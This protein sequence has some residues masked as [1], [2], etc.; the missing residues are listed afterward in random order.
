MKKDN[1][2]PEW[3]EEDFKKA[4]P[5]M[6]LPEVAEVLRK[7]RGPQK[8]PRKV[9]TSIRLS[10]EVLD[11]FESLGPGWQTKVDEVLK[12]YASKKNKAA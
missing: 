6:D 12:E 10:P 4:R 2:N 9:P 11:Y 7:G 1:E 5:A 8:K 3:T